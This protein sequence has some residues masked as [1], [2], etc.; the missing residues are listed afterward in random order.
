MKYLDTSWFLE[1]GGNSYPPGKPRIYFEDYVR[2]LRN[3][4]GER[5]IF[6][7][8]DTWENYNKLASVIS[9]R[10]ANWKSGRPLKKT[11]WQFWK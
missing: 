9:H 8:D 5:E 7:I 6:D 4:S 2:T 3:E 11:W 1:M 10:F